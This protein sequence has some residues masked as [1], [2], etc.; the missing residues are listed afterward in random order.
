M[1][2]ELDD[3]EEVI[4]Y[5]DLNWGSILEN[6]YVVVTGERLFVRPKKGKDIPGKYEDYVQLEVGLDEIE[7]V[8]RSGGLT[9]KDIE[10]ETGDEIHKIPDVTGNTDEIIQPVVEQ[11]GLQESD[12]RDENKSERATRGILGT[13]GA[14]FGIGIY[15]VSLLIG[16]SLMVLGLLATLTVAGAI[17]GIPLIIAGIFIIMGNSLFGAL[18]IKAGSWGTN[19]EEEWT[20]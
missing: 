14:S 12:W 10:I 6:A 2:P 20:R 15:A 4:S 13:I 9:S 7:K 8:R 3:D 19:Q 1:A 16:A 17:I 11:E 5:L 18:G